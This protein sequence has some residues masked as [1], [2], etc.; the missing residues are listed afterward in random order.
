MA[1]YGAGD[2]G[3]QL[4][5]YLRDSQRYRVIALIDDDHAL[6]GLTIWGVRIC[7]L[8]H[9]FEKFSEVDKVLVF[10]AM[11]SAHSFK[12][13]ELRKRLAEKGFP[14]AIM[15][16]ITEI[17]S[18]NNRFNE[19]MSFS[20]D[21]ILTRQVREPDRQLLEG[22]VRNKVV[23]VTGAGGSIGSEICRQLVK[24]NPKA[25]VLLDNSELALFK[26]LNEVNALDPILN[27]VPSMCSVQDEPSLN[28]VFD[29]NSIEVVFHAAAY[30][31]VTLSE[32]NV[33]EAVKNNVFG[34]KNLVDAALRVKVD[35]F[36]LISTD[37]AVRP[38]SVMGATKRLTELICSSNDKL[39]AAP[40]FASVR[41]G[42]VVGSSGSVVPIFS[43]QI[44]K[45]GPVTVTDFRATRFFM[46][47]EEAAQ[48]VLQ[49]ASLSSGNE[50]F[51]LDM[52]KPVNIKNVACNMI[53]MA[54]CEPIDESDCNV[55]QKRNSIVIS[56][57]RLKQ[58]EKV[59]E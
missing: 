37:K 55:P 42:N 4:L 26:I 50:V 27:V 41:F 31:H 35:K 36:V 45:G 13:N 38:T 6:Q 12:I 51:V 2:A 39:A 18:G 16:G 59:H 11:P 22:S 9:F 46:S 19:M 15:P 10:V 25:L 54:G 58:G 57:I 32:V 28:N 44:E 34:T 53:K 48:L 17:I 3:R 33:E 29:R 47:V 49:S 21:K 24:L 20:A 52:G 7:S 14:A 1:I 56:E 8:S 5:S 43:E 30:K 23:M 40:I